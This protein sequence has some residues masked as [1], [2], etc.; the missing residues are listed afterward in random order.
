MVVIVGNTGIM[1][2]ADMKLTS[3]IVDAAKERDAARLVLVAPGGG[4]GGVVCKIG[5]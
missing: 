2:K 5:Q 1:G 4:S 3:R